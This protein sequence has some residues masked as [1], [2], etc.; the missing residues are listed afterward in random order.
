M[1]KVKAN[2]AGMG[3]DSVLKNLMKKVGSHE[4]QV[5]EEVT[6][7]KEETAAAPQPQ[8]Q[9]RVVEPFSVSAGSA[10]D[11]AMAYAENYKEN[12]EETVTVVITKDMKAI[13]DRLRLSYGSYMPIKYLLSGLVREVIEDNRQEVMQRITKL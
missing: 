5:T 9:E 4:Q 1:P 10:L 3:N 2:T 11:R 6:G 8:K 13:I 12:Q 7:K